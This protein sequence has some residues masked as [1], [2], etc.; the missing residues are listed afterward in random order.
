MP[1]D[2]SL[3]E[4]VQAAFGP[5]I[6][7]DGFRVVESSD[8]GALGNALVVLERQPIRVRIASDRGDAYVDVCSVAD[9]GN[10]YPLAPL[11]SV[12][13]HATVSEGHSLGLMES[14]EL[15]MRHA[16]LLSEHLSPGG[17]DETKRKLEASGIVGEAAHYERVRKHLQEKKARDGKA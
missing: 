8:S 10:W 4:Q 17:L 3:L 11:L 1:D 7:Q 14:A 12:L 2:S 16:E 5:L 15:L 6:S 13:A 9:P